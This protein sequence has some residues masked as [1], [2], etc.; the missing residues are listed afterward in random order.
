MPGDNISI[1]HTSMQRA[2]ADSRAHPSRCELECGGGG[3]GGG[4]PP[5][6]PGAIGSA[7]IP[8]APGPS[9]IGATE[10]D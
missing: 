3:G 7:N 4:A 1:K 10:S 5:C 6:A 9:A 8:C 2:H